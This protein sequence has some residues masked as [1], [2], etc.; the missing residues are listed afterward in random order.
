[1]VRSYWKLT[2]VAA[3]A[4]A[5]LVWGQQGQ[6]PALLPAPEPAKTLPMAPAAPKA[7]PVSAAAPSDAKKPTAAMPMPSDAAAK[8]APVG[9]SEPLIKV[10]EEGKP[11]QTCRV[12][13]AWQMGN[14]VNAREVQDIASGEIMTIVDGMP[15]AVASGPAP[16]PRGAGLASRVYHWG[17]SKTAPA[18][19][20][21]PPST[22]GDGP[23]L[24][25]PGSAS[26][27]KLVSEPVSP[28]VHMPSERTPF[29]RNWFQ[30]EK[31]VHT[32]VESTRPM[33]TQ[34][35][36]PVVQASPGTVVAPRS[37][38][39]TAGSAKGSALPV[40]GC[41]AKS[42]VG[43]SS[44]AAK[45]SYGIGVYSACAGKPFM[46]TT[47]PSRPY[48]SP[49][50]LVT[51]QPTP[52]TLVTKQPVK[53]A[54]DAP[55]PSDWRRSWGK[56][57]TTQV[58]TLPRPTAGSTDATAKAPAP[59]WPEDPSKTTKPA[60]VAAT[61]PPAPR[62]EPKPVQTVRIELPH[63]DPKAADPLRVP[64]QF[65]RRPVDTTPE[66]PKPVAVKKAPE[67]AVAA[68]P[69][70]KPAP[71]PTVDP[72]AAGVAT[73]N[74]RLPMG[75][76]SVLA[77]YG[78]SPA[79]VVY[80]PVPMVTLPQQTVAQQRQQAPSAPSNPNAD[81]RDLNAFM[82]PAN[83]QAPPSR[84]EQ[85]A[86]NAFSSGAARSMPAYRPAASGPMSQ[87][88]M[89]AMGYA[90]APMPGPYGQ[91]MAQAGYYPNPYAPAGYAM[92]H[93]AMMYPPAMPVSQPVAQPVNYQ[94][95]AAPAAQNPQQLML[96][97]KDALYPSHRE[98]A[99]EALASTDW[100]NNPGIVDALVLSAKEDPAATVRAGAVRAL[101]R[102]HA[103]STTVVTTL[104]GL[105]SDAD[106]RVRQD[107]EQALTSM[108]V[109]SAP[110]V[111]PVSGVM[112]R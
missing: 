44:G 81:Q 67:K 11:E 100:K 94:Q 98:W 64:D 62:S 5:G 87:A 69:E 105:R 99:A 66:A 28:R 74:P 53:P 6:G 16:A 88:Q 27:P 101:G 110:V 24:V 47:Y 51:K 37:T 46:P 108:N 43:D 103:N 65:S 107:V 4:G 26:P 39:A 83:M 56:P 80:L 61:P 45:P 21:V 48:H 36:T 63:A 19:I 13:K 89:M 111:Q 50:S 35:P 15:S 93:P 2:L 70:P 84:E 91:P 73:T 9:S 72:G 52:S 23:V 20:P 78:E 59:R 104:Q 30:G 95:S 109:P 14:G 3:L 42:S 32:P 96:T 17:R 79:G 58:Q 71:V 102:M 76:G 55:Q 29:W 97:L 75:A 60:T 8:V 34:L 38:S 12:L 85:M 33:R 77:A 7:A 31:V 112:P 57:E 86:S 90:P 68:K 40:L 82:G 18:G 10:R 41:E 1:M 92:P 49:S 25:S 54:T 106:P 22:G